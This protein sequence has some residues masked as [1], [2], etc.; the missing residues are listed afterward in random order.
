MARNVAYTPEAHPVACWFIGGFIC[1]LGAMLLFTG[2]DNISHDPAWMIPQIAFACALLTLGVR[3][4]LYHRRKVLTLTADAIQLRPFWWFAETIPYAQI[5]ALEFYQQ[6]NLAKDY[7]RSVTGRMTGAI[8]TSQHLT[9]RMT[10]GKTRRL[11][12]PAYDNTHLIEL[13]QRRTGLRYT[14][15]SPRIAG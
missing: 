2:I 1:V 9:L 7:T 10:S 15:T 5:E 14:R 4:G 6:G 12:L 3:V 11:V 13:L 8:V